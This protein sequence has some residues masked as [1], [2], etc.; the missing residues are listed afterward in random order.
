MSNTQQHRPITNAS[1]SNGEPIL[2]GAATVVH[3][4]DASTAVN[5]GP[6]LDEIT[7]WL[8]NAH[9]AAQ[10]ASVTIGGV[11]LDFT[12]PAGTSLKVLD[13][14]PLR[15]AAAGT[16][17]TVTVGNVTQAADLTAYGYITR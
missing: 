10:I 1:G 8:N 7:L 6:Y 12:I 4:T 16:G 13:E 9:T 3:T 2:C 17:A 11:Q 5:G 15:G 14:V